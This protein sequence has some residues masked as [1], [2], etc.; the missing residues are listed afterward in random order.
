MRKSQEC[1]SP[2]D[3]DSQFDFLPPDI[4]TRCEKKIGTFRPDDVYIASRRPA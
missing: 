4:L 1:S 2:R 3:V